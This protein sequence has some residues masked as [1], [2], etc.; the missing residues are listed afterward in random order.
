MSYQGK[1]I[2]KLPSN[3]NSIDTVMN[4]P[5]FETF[6]TLPKLSYLINLFES[7]PDLLSILVSMPF[8]FLESIHGINRAYNSDKYDNL[9]QIGTSL[10]NSSKYENRLYEGV[11][12]AYNNSLDIDYLTEVLTE[13]N[14]DSVPIDGGN[15]YNEMQSWQQESINVLES[16]KESVSNLLN[17]LKGKKLTA[18]QRKQRT[19]LSWQLSDLNKIYSQIQSKLGLRTLEDRNNLL[20]IILN[21]NRI[22][23]SFVR[24]NPL[25]ILDLP[26]IH[27]QFNQFQFN[28][29]NHQFNQ[30]QLNKRQLTDI[31]STPA[32]MLAQLNRM[33]NFFL[34]FFGIPVNI[35]L[36]PALSYTVS[37]MVLKS[38]G[39]SGAMATRY[40]AGHILRQNAVNLPVIV[41]QTGMWGMAWGYLAPFAPWVIL[42]SVTIVVGIKK[43]MKLGEHLYLFGEHSGSYPDMTFMVLSNSNN[44][45]IYETMLNQGETMKN[46]S[47]KTYSTLYGFSTYKDKPQFGLDLTN[48]DVTMM[49][50]TELNSFDG[51]LNII[52]NFWTT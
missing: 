32:D 14:I 23:P 45:E 15:P 26:Q 42:A 16:I 17:S 2:L 25:N 34:S 18:E 11:F 27:N 20:E 31:I 12:K 39:S 5:P 9:N 50:R 49:N 10:L 29:F 41:Q 28:Q 38:L 13:N 6:R 44:K 37:N 4:T 43:N 19:R 8:T 47:G 24:T 3:L 48:D 22:D 7:V 52:D 1:E 40:F 46:N 36:L 30:N 33:S 35:N 51:Y 21:P